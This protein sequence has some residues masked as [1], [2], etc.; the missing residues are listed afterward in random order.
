MPMEPPEWS[1]DELAPGRTDHL[2][3]VDLNPLPDGMA[4]G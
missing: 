4:E 3:E 1:G 2:C